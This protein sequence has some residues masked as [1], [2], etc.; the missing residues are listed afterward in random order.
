M[1]VPPENQAPGGGKTVLN[2]YVFYP[3]DAGDH[4]LVLSNWV[5][6]RAASTG[7]ARFPLRAGQTVYAFP[8][9]A[10]KT[11][12]RMVVVPVTADGPGSAGVVVSGGGVEFA[13]SSRQSV[14]Q[15]EPPT[16]IPD[17]TSNATPDPTDETT[18]P[19]S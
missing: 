12:L 14:D 6:C 9:F 17:S 2:S 16:T 1:P 4:E 15:N 10:T 13:P 11:E 8:W 5:H 18:T 19:T 3:F 7:K